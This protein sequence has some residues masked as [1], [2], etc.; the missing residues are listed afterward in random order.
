MR[1]TYLLLFLSLIFVIT[2]CGRGRN[3][4]SQAYDNND[5]VIGSSSEGD[6]LS[7]PYHHVDMDISPFVTRHGHVVQGQALDRTT[8]LRVLAPTTLMDAVEAAIWAMGLS[9]EELVVEVEFYHWGTFESLSSDL[10][11]QFAAGV[12]PDIILAEV[13]LNPEVTPFHTLHKNGW[14]ADIYDIIDNATYVSRSDFFYNVFVANEINNGLYVIPLNFQLQFVGVNASL[15]QWFI[16]EFKSLNYISGLQLAHMYTSLIEVY[17]QYSRFD[18]S[19][20]LSANWNRAWRMFSNDIYDF[21]DLNQFVSRFDSDE[22]VQLLT[23]IQHV[24]IEINDVHSQFQNPTLPIETATTMNNIGE[25]YAFFIPQFGLNAVNAL[26]P[27]DNPYFLHYI[28]LTDSEGRLITSNSSWR[29]MAAINKDANQGAAFRF[30]QYVSNYY[31]L[32]QHSV[33]INVAQ[34][35]FPIERMHLHESV[36]NAVWQ[37]IQRTASQSFSGQNDFFITNQHIDL[38]VMQLEDLLMLPMTVSPVPWYIPQHLFAE[39]FS[40]LLNK[41]AT[42]FEVA[43]VMQLAVSEWLQT[44]TTV[45]VPHVDDETP[46][47][48]LTILA[49]EGYYSIIRQAEREMMA[50]WR[51][52]GAPYNFRV[53]LST[54][55]WVDWPNVSQRL[56]TMMMGGQG[57]DLIFWENMSLRAW[58]ERGFLTDIYQLMTED[59]GVTREDFFVG[60]LSAMEIDGALYAMPISIAFRYVFINEKLPQSIL[61]MFSNHEMI[62]FYDMLD[63]Y[64]ALMTNYGDT[65]GHLRFAQ[66]SRTSFDEIIF[67]HIRNY[68]DFENNI[69]Y[70]NSTSF[71][72]TLENI[73]YYIGTQ[74][75]HNIHNPFFSFL[76]T[77]HDTVR[78]FSQQYTFI[79][80]WDWLAPGLAFVDTS[81]FIHGI[82]ITDNQGRIK[83]EMSPGAPV[84]NA[85]ISPVAVTTLADGALAW[86]FIQH[87]IPVFNQPQVMALNEGMMTPRWG[88]WNSFSAPIQRS[89]FEPF[90]RDAFTGFFSFTTTPDYFFVPNIHALNEVERARILS[91][92]M[93][94]LYKYSNTAAMPPFDFIHGNLFNEN[95]A[96]YIN[97]VITAQEFAQRTH[98]AITLWFM[99]Q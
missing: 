17:P 50:S 94:R 3:N 7:S 29:Q 80:E 42:P 12:G 1:Y 88:F 38:A 77:G 96:L 69:S 36:S 11:I 57:F 4:L 76:H 48:V 39:S 26:I 86:E 62:S 41:S 20:G 65:Y 51:A 28:P 24:S 84:H 25:H 9:C 45:Y 59:Q 18:F 32:S 35:V 71:I 78:N 56:Q 22:F 16:D 75:R 91:D 21:V 52:T 98:N 54:Y 64:I 66:G 82:P 2:A 87:I 95:L 23:D 70:I 67:D 44:W 73:R 90:M 55:R 31:A 8:I 49:R 53:D 37:V 85:A 43:N 99:E 10:L 81:Y 97:S 83:L 30:I 5:A 68:V 79:I 34:L 40:S 58:A 33:D 13:G 14:L 15:P 63:I 61:N 19:H 93:A 46:T 47:R 27:V 60:A 92:A 6:I 72:D 89:L 74:S